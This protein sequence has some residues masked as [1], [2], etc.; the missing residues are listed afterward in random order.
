MTNKLSQG[1]YVKNYAVIKKS[2]YNL[3]GWD[4]YN[5]GRTVVERRIKCCQICKM[6][7]LAKIVCEKCPDAEFSSGPYFPIFSPNTEKYGPEKTPC[8]DTFHAVK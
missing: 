1:P 7:C 2:I 3:I 6:K 5:I 4:E 8:L